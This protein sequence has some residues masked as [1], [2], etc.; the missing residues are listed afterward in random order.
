[1]LF[2]YSVSTKNGQIK[3]GEI[4]AGSKDEAAKILL[5]QDLIIISLEVKKI[6]KP[7]DLSFGSVSELDKINLVRNLQMMIR[8]GLPLGEAL[9]ILAEQTV[10]HKLKIIINDIQKGVERGENL[11]SSFA[12]YPRYFS[13]LFIGVI[14]TAESSGTLESSLNY[15]TEQLEKSYELKKKVQSALIYPA[16]IVIMAIVLSLGLSQFLLPKILTLFTKL[17][18]SLPLITRIFL[19]VMN[20]LAKNTLFILLGFI[21]L[22]LLLRFLS[23]QRQTKLLFHTFYLKLPVLGPLTRNK[24]L[25][26][27]SRTSQTLLKSGLTLPKSLEV[28]AETIGNQVYQKNLEK[29][30]PHLKRGETLSLNLESFPREFPLSLAKILSVGEKTGNLEDSFRY[31]ADFYEAEVDR[32]IKNLTVVLEPILLIFIGLG[33]GLLAVSIIL[34][35]YQFIGQISQ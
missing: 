17:E 32:A 20:F 1:M 23:R 21:A 28:V 22:I 12:L 6:K 31:L 3:K 5:A 26:H 4:E 7:I 24:N 16:I 29:I 34:P 30:I 18:I 35:I 14:K 9:K 2:Q 8:S 13:P 19:A 33:V 10:S 11:S 15:L 25:A 27:F